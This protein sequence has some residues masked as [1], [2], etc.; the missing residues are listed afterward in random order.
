MGLWAWYAFVGA[1]GQFGAD[2]VVAAVIGCAAVWRTAARLT[3]AFMT[4]IRQGTRIVVSAAC[5]VIGNGYAGARW[6]GPLFAEWGRATITRHITVT[7]NT[8]ATGRT[9]F[10]Y[11]ALG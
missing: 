1:A 11:S 3:D 4:I 2:P 7:N 9:D 5:S 6:A 8:Q 10:V